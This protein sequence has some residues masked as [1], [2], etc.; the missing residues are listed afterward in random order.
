MVAGK[1]KLPGALLG[2]VAALWLSLVFNLKGL[3]VH[4]IHKVPAGMPHFQ[5]P[6]LSLIQAATL[7][8]SALAIAV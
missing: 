8:S 5:M 1:R 2:L 7:F 3:G 6:E 4:M